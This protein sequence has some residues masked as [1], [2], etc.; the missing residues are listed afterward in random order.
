MIEIGRDPTLFSLRTPC[1]ILLA[2]ALGCAMG[3]NIAVEQKCRSLFSIEDFSSGNINCLN[4]VI[5]NKNIKDFL[6]LG[7]DS[8]SLFC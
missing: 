3:S 2:L 6:T 8:I 4:F 7:N 1:S 5:L